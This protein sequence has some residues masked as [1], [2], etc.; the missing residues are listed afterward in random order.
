[1]TITSGRAQLLPDGGLFI[2][3]TDNG[4]Q[5]RYTQNALLWSRINDYDESRVGLLS[6]SRYLTAEEVRIPLKALAEKSC[7]NTSDTP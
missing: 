7:Q 3:E 2:E 5:L 6:W 1:M 4:R